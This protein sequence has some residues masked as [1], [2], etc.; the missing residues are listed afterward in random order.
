MR[1]DILS[2][3]RLLVSSC[4]LVTPAWQLLGVSVEVEGVGFW[5]PARYTRGALPNGAEIRPVTNLAIDSGC[6]F[7]K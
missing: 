2:A 7:P 4:P 3:R 6:G 5:D 1:S